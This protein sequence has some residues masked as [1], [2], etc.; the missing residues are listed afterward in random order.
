M[1][2]F[3]RIFGG[4]GMPVA[5]D[6]LVKRMSAEKRDFD[7]IGIDDEGH[8]K[9][10]YVCGDIAVT[11]MGRTRMT[12]LTPCRDTVDAAC[13]RLKKRQTDLF[14][15]SPAEFT[16]AFSWKNGGRVKA[17]A[18]FD[19]STASTLADWLMEKVKKVGE[20]ISADA[21][22]KLLDGEFSSEEPPQW[23]RIS[24]MEEVAEEQQPV[25]PTTADLKPG[26]MVFD[27]YRIERELGGGG[28]G[29]V[30][31]ATDTKTVV[32][33]RRQIVL[34]VL[35]CGNGGGK[36]ALAELIKEA[37]TLSELHHDAIAACYSC[38]LLGDEPILAMEYIE[39][40][41]LADYLAR[42]KGGKIDEATTQELLRPIAEALDYAHKKNIFHR[43]VK[44]H[45]I[46]VRKVPKLGLKTCLLDFGIAGTAQTTAI[47]TSGQG[48]VGTIQYM[49]PGQKLGKPASADM[50]VY[51]LAVTAYECIMGE[52]PYPDG[53]F[54][55]V[56]VKPIASNTP[57]ARAVMRGLEMMPDRRPATCCALVDPPETETDERPGTISFDVPVGQKPDA[58]KRNAGPILPDDLAELGHSFTVYRMMLAQ[59]A[60][61]CE[62]DDQQ[63]ASWLRDRQARL[64]DLTAGNVNVA[65]LEA[66]FLEVAEH[67]RSSRISADDF[68]V[69]HDRLEELRFGLPKKGGRVLRALAASIE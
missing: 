3:S 17:T 5:D 37:N 60:A 68:F 53:W 29:R 16:V 25:I 18:T 7:G 4:G 12:R 10:V 66:F 44:P 45:N 64:R 15:V 50:D 38:Q 67:L 43:D 2:L 58:A 63:R 1:G 41:S 11:Q 39:G 24:K 49:S 32:E 21:L 55:N 40:V 13:V 42:S 28:Q 59:S 56:N 47:G 54:P 69:Q 27:C 6:T 33:S 30:F 20:N 52:L 62:R 48:A 22:G 65:A 51:S 31:L 36:E 23:L 19:R 35:H 61:K 14:Y 34:K 46:V 26:D 8:P 57:F 9:D